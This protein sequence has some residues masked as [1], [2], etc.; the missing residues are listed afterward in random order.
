MIEN[1]IKKYTYKVFW[2]EEDKEFVAVCN[3]I[4]TISGLG[5]SP[6]KAFMELMFVME[7]LIS[8]GDLV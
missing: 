7:I 4:T 2:S 1:N 3:E 5:S 8:H 6:K